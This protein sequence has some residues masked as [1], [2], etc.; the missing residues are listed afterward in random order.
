MFQKPCANV[1]ICGVLLLGLLLSVHEAH[2]ITEVGGPIISDTTWTVA[3]SPY[4]VVASLDVWAGVTLRIEPGVTVKFAPNT[5]LQVNG[6]LIARGTAARPVI[7]TSTEATPRPGNWRGIE[8]T[9]T[10]VPTTVDASGNYISGSVLQYCVVAFGGASLSG[11]ITGN[12]L[13]VDHCHIHH[14]DRRGITTRGSAEHLSWITNNRIEDNV[15]RVERVGGGGAFAVN[16]VVRNNTIARNIGWNTGGGL[17]V[18]YS[19]VDGNTIEHNEAIG[20]GLGGGVYSRA[21]EIKG[22]TIR[23]NGAGQGGGIDAVEGGLIHD[24]LVQAN[25]ATSGQGGGIWA[26]ALTVINDNWII[27][28]TARGTD[29]LGGGVLAGAYTVR[30]GPKV[31]MRGNVVM[32]NS[33]M[34]GRVAQGGGIFAVSRT[35]V[36]NTVSHNIVASGRGN[37]HGGGVFAHVNTAVL[38]NTI[39]SNQ[40]IGQGWPGGAG[41]YLWLADE[42]EHNTVVGNSGPPDSRSGGIE[43]DGG[44]QVHYNTIYA[45]EPFDVTVISRGDISGTLNFWATADNAN[46]LDRIHD[47][48]DDNNRGK[49]LFIPFESSAAPDSPL[50]PPSGLALSQLTPGNDGKL[51][52]SWPGSP[53]FTTGWGYK[54]YYDTDDPIPP[55]EGTSLGPGPSGIDVGGQTRITLTG[56]RPAQIYYFAVTT[57]DAQ[58]HESWY[59]NVV[60]TVP[61]IE[62]FL[63]AVIDR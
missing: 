17:H 25:V 43:I 57:Y 53:S 44:S 14:N 46:I 30:P 24:N 3:N 45:N 27:E 2:A 19:L 5:L 40:A 35:V 48:Y 32:F 62:Y 60:A 12:S 59:S 56:L 49:F 37:A 54:L 39:S 6:E 29:A 34:G 1:L 42:F 41:A 21:S 15:M 20:H 13:L 38:S 51:T 18:E 28:N 9:S 23:S 63:P 52:L 11:V 10:A 61:R 55:Y 58:G 36:G 16:A 8:F 22:N 26:G 50:P 7:F 4:L 47:W 33:A 31:D